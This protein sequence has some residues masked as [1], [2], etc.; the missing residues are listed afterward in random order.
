MQSLT[1]SWDGNGNLVIR[2]DGLKADGSESFAYDGLNRLTQVSTGAAGAVAQSLQYNSIGNI[3]E[4]SDI[5][6]YAYTSA[7]P[8]AVTQ[9]G[10]ETYGYD[11]LGRQVSRTDNGRTLITS[12]NA[13]AKPREV[14]EGSASGALLA[15]YSY[16]AEGDRLVKRSPT[17]TT[18]YIGGLYERRVGGPNTSEQFSIVA[19][20]RVVAVMRRNG[21]TSGDGATCT[22]TT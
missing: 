5:G 21:S 4:R 22:P 14:H 11:E 2:Q 18:V 15:G 16:T 8:H 3:L 9:A 12:Y 13:W 1:H 20:G 17:E 19:G 6:S 7:Q 10:S